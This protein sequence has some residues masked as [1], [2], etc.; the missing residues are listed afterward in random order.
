M[1]EAV[2]ESMAIKKQVF[3]ELD[4]ICRPG[5]ILGSNTSTLDVDEIA[6]A[7]K[8]PQDVIG[9]HF[10]SPAN[11]M[12]LL[13]IIRGKDTALDVQATALALAP[14]IGKTGVMVGN[15]YGFAG[16][17]M[18]EGFSREA[19]YLVLEGIEP[20]RID[21]AMQKFGLA[22]GPF[23]VADLVG[24]DVPYKARQENSQA[25]KGDQAYYRLADTL[26]EME[27]FGQK[28]GRGY[29]IYDAETR[30]PKLDPEIMDIAAKEAAALGIA[31]RLDISDEEIAERCIL[32]VIA[33]G[34]K[35]LEEGIA[36]R[37]SDLD[38]IYTLGYG[39]PA[40]R[41]GPMHFADTVGLQSIVAQ[42]AKYAEKYDYYWQ[43]CGLLTELA[44]SGQS[45]ADFDKALA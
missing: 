30:Q 29:Y 9:L 6:S 2:F 18:V 17:R 34:A 31:P 43:P 39:F 23:A 25:A 8:R 5:A 41:G 11:I 4:R 15:C 19:N 14:Q 10:F 16:N 36:V 45:F 24:I 28:T 33:E 21:S 35:I 12:P 3:A 42:M 44:T 40:M 26:V 22:M 37:A 38:L 27:R 7:T 20:H 1:I 32:P 13:E